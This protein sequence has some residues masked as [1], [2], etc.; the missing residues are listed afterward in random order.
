MAK[1]AGGMALTIFEYPTPNMGR[2]RHEAFL[3]LPGA[4]AKRAGPMVA[5]VTPP[6]DADAA[7][8]VLAKS[9]RGTGLTTQSGR[10][11]YP[12]S[13]SR[14]SLS[15]PQFLLAGVLYRR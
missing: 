14:K 4:I 2:E 5:V 11:G 7:E 1:Y 13:G 8:R 9:S 3:K 10:P 6:V 12:P 15:L